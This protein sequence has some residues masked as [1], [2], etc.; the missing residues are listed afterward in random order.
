MRPH[1]SPS[2]NCMRSAASLACPMSPSGGPC[3]APGTRPW[4]ALQPSDLKALSPHPG[5]VQVRVGTII[6][7][8]IQSY[9]PTWL[10]SPQSSQLWPPW[11]WQPQCRRRT[12]PSWARKLLLA[13]QRSW[14]CPSRHRPWDPSGS[15]RPL[16]QHH[17]PRP[18]TPPP[19]PSPACRIANG[20]PTPCLA[21]TVCTSMVSCRG[22]V[23]GGGRGP[24]HRSGVSTGT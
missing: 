1:T 9:K 22:Q 24:G 20:S 17:G 14:A 12:G 10:P 7:E 19:S 8:D 4:P 6:L 23:G 16:S 13:S 21:R 11:G 5:H 2:M 3:P 18:S 15:T